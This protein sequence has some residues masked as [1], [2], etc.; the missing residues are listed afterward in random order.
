MFN[1]LNAV[2]SCLPGLLAAIVTATAGCQSAGTDDSADTAAAPVTDV[3]VLHDFDAGILLEV[4]S[5]ETFRIELPANR[6]TGY[7][8]SITG[9]LDASIVDL[10][11]SHYLPEGNRPGAGG[12]S[13]WDFVARAPGTTLVTLGYAR[14]WEKDVAPAK[15]LT[16]RVHVR[17]A[18]GA[19]GAR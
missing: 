5:G 9:A 7:E 11:D 4:N 6:T 1:R 16:Y 3:A 19:G 10:H 17:G 14:P 12:V 13:V 8:W 15:S 2:R 18:A